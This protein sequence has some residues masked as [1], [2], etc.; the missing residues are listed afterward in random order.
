[1]RVLHTIQTN[2]TLITEEW[3]LFFKR[4][5]YLVGVSI[6]GPR[7]MHDKYRIDKQNRGSFE[8]VMRG[9]RILR[10]HEVDVNILCTVHAGNQDHPLEVYRFFRDTLQAT[11]IQ[12]IP[13][14]ERATEAT[15]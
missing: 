6:D 10:A 5:G 2:G 1:Q 13:I 9:W 11:H 4:H 8:D 3:A 15:L 7:G 12:L 14:V